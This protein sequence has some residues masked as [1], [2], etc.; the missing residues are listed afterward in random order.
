MINLKLFLNNLIFVKIE[1]RRN[2][3]EKGRLVS[4]EIKKPTIK[5]A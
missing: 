5:L 2:N 3:T 1:G 4:E